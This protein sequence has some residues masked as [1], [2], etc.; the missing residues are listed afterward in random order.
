MSEK[1][2]L[3]RRTFLYTSAATAGAVM[4]GACSS[5]EQSPTSP[6]STKKPGGGPSDAPKGS[7]TK[8]LTKPAK[9]NESPMLAEQVKAGSLPAIEQRLPEN[10]YVIPHKWVKPGK[11]GGNLMMI[12][13]VAT[14]GAIAASNKEYSYGHSLLRWLNDGLNIGPGLVESWESND[15]ASEWT[16][17]FR[18]GL[19]WSDGEPWTTADIMFWWEDLVLNQDHTDVP[20]DECKSGTGKVATLTA[21]DEVTLV[22]KFDVPA[23]LTA[24]RL[25]MWVNGTVGNGPKWMVPRHYAQQFHPKY[26]KKV[27]K[28]WAAVGGLFERKVDYSREPACP[29]MTGWKLKSLKEGR[30]ISWE[31]NP[32]YY[33]VMPNGDQLPYVD[34]L[35]MS[36]VQDK[37]VGKLQMTQGKLDYVH[38][39]FYSVDLP[40]I[41]TMK[42][43]ES[44][45]GLDVVL[46]DGGS[47]TGSIFFFNYDHPDENFRALIREPKFRKALSM[48]V[49]RS[50][51]QKAVYFNTG[52]Q[53]TGTLSPK[54]KEYLASDEGKQV[55]KDWRDMAVKYDPEAAKK[56]LD[57]LGVVDKDGDGMREFP[58]GQKLTV[59]LDYPA[60]TSDE[61]KKKNNYLERDWK[62]IGINAKQNPVAPDGW[63]DS[64]KA[65]K[66]TSHTAW[67]V[68]D[69]PNHLVYPQWL[70]PI[71]PERYCPLEGQ[72]YNVRGTPDEGKQLNVDPYKRTPPRM[73]PEKG[74]PVEQLWKLY[75]QTKVEPDEMK[76]HA[77]VWEMIKIHIEHGPFFMGTVANTPRVVLAKKELKNIPRKENLA[78]GGF[79]NP[80]I[81]P[82]PA[83]YDPETFYWE[84]PD[85]H[86]V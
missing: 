31:R 81:H 65:G 3:K 26:N 72:W 21:P 78:L 77:L 80:W 11:F 6:G 10:P 63:S 15:D 34:T 12:S 38:G 47:G 39:A 40:D 5:N 28:N 8:P 59:R 54:A 86:T 53:T 70:V 32:F 19:K 29:T 37:Q 61:H 25:A 51:I 18:K 84:N 17:H 58:N 24:D 16:L 44:T 69:G 75:D 82:T 52:E 48:A 83:V 13:D 46:W 60:D 42:Q 50:E 55:Y 33:C 67:E 7:E 1:A 22:M 62:A 45:S 49:N 64:W 66:L 85:Q 36:I 41:S 74:G 57:E 35:T 2:T 71:E 43:S 73:E 27:P 14:G 9:F 76:R 23:P 20:P 68:G 4:L 79:A 56:L 30:T